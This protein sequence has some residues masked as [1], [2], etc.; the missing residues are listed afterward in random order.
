[1]CARTLDVYG[2]VL[3]GRAARSNADRGVS[4]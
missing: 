4:R 3:A 2:A 1:M